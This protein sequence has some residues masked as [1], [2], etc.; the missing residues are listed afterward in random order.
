MYFLTLA[1]LLPFLHLTLAS[2]QPF[3]QDLTSRACEA[4][5][6][7]SNYYQIY[8]DPEFINQTSGLGPFSPNG[9]FSFAVSQ[10]ANNVNER[11]L[12]V[13]FKNVPCP[14]AGSGPYKLEFL[15]LPDPRYTVSGTNTRV[16]V[17]TI[18]GDLPAIVFSDGS[19]SEYPQWDSTNRQTGPRIG[20]F[21]FPT[22]K[23]ANKAKTLL[24][25]KVECMSTI[26]LRFSITN[27][28][29]QAGNINYFHDTSAGLRI[30]YRC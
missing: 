1:S 2:P 24:S 29:P 11:D 23:A 10:L 8:E 16:D 25:L 14:P 22:G 19:I 20:S 3:T 17:F 13:S 15:F 30:R 27:D 7:P 4:I 9:G 28:S 12:V 21:T 18:N 5:L 6:A 26:N